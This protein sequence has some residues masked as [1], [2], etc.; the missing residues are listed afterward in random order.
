[1]RNNAQLKKVTESDQVRHIRVK[2]REIKGM[3]KNQSLKL[4]LWLRINAGFWDNGK[5]FLNFLNGKEFLDQLTLSA[6]KE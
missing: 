4:W 3:L 2:T 6:Y 5:T 1:V